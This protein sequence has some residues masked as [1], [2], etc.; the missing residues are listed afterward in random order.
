MAFYIEMDKI[1]D[2]EEFVDYSF[3]R[4]MDVG[5]LRL[6]KVRGTLTVLSACPLDQDGEWSQRASMKLARLWKEGVY[7]DKTQWAS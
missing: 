4:G 5:V 1:A 2:T 3:G 7:P 6:N